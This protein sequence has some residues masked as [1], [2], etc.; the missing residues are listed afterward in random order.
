LKQLREED[1]VVIEGQ[2]VIIKDVDTL[3]RL[4]DFERTYLSRFQ[5]SDLLA[6]K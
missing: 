2:R 6:K 4:A 1:L 5:L 3:G